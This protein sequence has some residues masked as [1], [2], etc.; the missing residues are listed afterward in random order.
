MKACATGYALTYVTTLKLQL[1][2][3]TVIGLTAAKFKPLILPF[4]CPI[5]LTFG[6][7]W[8]RVTS[9]CVLHNLVIYSYTCKEV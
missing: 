8:F 7:T 9:V 5:P 6:F 4:P 1:V 2:S 3:R